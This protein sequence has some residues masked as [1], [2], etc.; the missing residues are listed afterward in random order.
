[1]INENEMKKY[2]IISLLLL[3]NCCLFSQ[4]GVLGG[5]NLSSLRSN[6][7]KSKYMIGF[8]VGGFYN[9]HLF[10]N[11]YFHPQILL[12]YEPSSVTYNS[13]YEEK[14]YKIEF[15][16]NGF[17]I[18]TP[19]ML[20]YKIPVKRESQFGINLGPYLSYGLSG[21]MKIN[22]WLGDNF[23]SSSKPL[24]PDYSGRL[25][26]GLIGGVKY[27]FKNYLLSAHVKY[28]LNTVNNFEDRSIAIMTSIGYKFR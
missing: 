28:G 21:N 22:T 12:S 5:M 11:F 17:H 15:K 3:F 4:I 7:D 27:E 2:I 6:A 19:T 23:S 8:H 10:D 18:T 16:A 13:I 14:P 20:S 24:F 26:I 25:E 9:L 1:M